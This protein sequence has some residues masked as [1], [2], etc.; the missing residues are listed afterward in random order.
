MQSNDVQDELAAGFEPTAL[1]PVAP[2][3]GLE[4]PPMKPPPR[5]PP[6]LCEQGPC[7]NYHVFKIQLDAQKP[8]ATRDEQGR[9]LEHEAADHV[10]TH[11]Y[12]YPTVGIESKLGSLPVVS[13]NRWDPLTFTEV[14]DQERRVEGWLN[15]E[16]GR[17]Y[18]AELDAYQAEQARIES[19]AAAAAAEAAEDLA[20]MPPGEC[21]LRMEV[22]TSRGVFP[23][24]GA[25]PYTFPWNATLGTVRELALTV[26]CGS[27][28]EQQ[29]YSI[30][31]VQP[32]V[33]Q[34]W[35]SE[36][37][38]PSQT[39]SQVGLSSGDLVLFDSIHKETP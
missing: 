23:V 26:H 27:Y 37:L 8:M 38:D 13:C 7:R 10:E 34:P 32:R 17:E 18:V 15:S 12:C 31:R 9:L 16:R 25:P 28:S 21:E 22:R 30:H 5:H 35:V 20:A 39:I 6:R 3:G 1:P 14:N 4:L 29:N 36:P 2:D 19:S 24:H 33:G 11:H